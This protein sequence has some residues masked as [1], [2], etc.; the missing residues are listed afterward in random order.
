VRTFL[1]RLGAGLA[2]A[3]GGLSVW[4]APPADGAAV[5][6]QIPLRIIVYPLDGTVRAAYRLGQP[7]T[8][9]RFARALDAIRSRSWIMKT[10]GLTLDHDQI[11]ADN[12]SSFREFTIAIKPDET[13]ADRVYPALFKVG[14]E[15]LALYTPYLAGDLAAWQSFVQPKLP[16]TAISLAGEEREIGVFGMHGVD[17]YLYLGPPDYL[18]RRDA[19]F[20]VPPDLPGWIAE[21]A[22]SR[23]EQIREFYQTRLGWTLPVTPTVLMAYADAPGPSRY[24]GDVSAGWIMALRFRGAGWRERAPDDGYDILH[25]IAHESFHLWNG[26]LF[27]S[28]DL[29]EQPWLHEGGAEYAALLVLRNFGALSDEA[30]RDD[31]ETRL[32]RCRS[33]LG[34][35]PLTAGSRLGNGAGRDFFALWH[36]L[37]Q[38]ASG[39]QS[40]YA[41]EDF[42]QALPPAARPAIDLILDQGG[43]ARWTALPDRLKALGVDLTS[44]GADATDA[45]LRHRA[46]L[47]LLNQA[48]GGDRHGFATEPGFLQFDTGAGCGPLA[49]DPSIASAEGHDLFRDMPGAFAAIARKCGSATP[50]VLG[51]ESAEESFAV[52]CSKPLPAEPHAILG[53]TGLP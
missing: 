21:T 17:R 49:G 19:L 31:L 41:V 13:A 15:G 20:V 25:L 46:V 48:C 35:A 50:V 29:D 32:D 1:R 36:D 33:D 26:M 28:R 44:P 18:Q 24:R 11:T 45:A 22:E 40:S 5:D 12:G 10:P 51:G 6:G 8:H 47:H 2:I 16:A 42:E 23:F 14:P 38:S 34:A 4:L 43:A 30:F 27:N 9:F 37:F 7:V 52:P 3:L 53:G 39:R